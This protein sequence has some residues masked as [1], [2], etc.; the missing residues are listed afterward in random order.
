MSDPFEGRL[1]RCYELAGRRAAFE[2]RDPDLYLVHGTIE[3][4]GLPAIGHAWVEHSDGTVYE[5]A[6]NQIWP[7]LAFEGFFN[8]DPE[9]KYHKNKVN[10]IISKEG[11]WGPWHETKGLTGSRKMTKYYDD[12]VAKKKK[13][14]VDY[15]HIIKDRKGEP[16]DK[17]LYSQVKSE[18]KKKFDVYPSA[19]ANAWVVKQYKKRGGT[20]S[21]GKKKS[22]SKWYDV[23]N[24]HEA[25]AITDFIV[26]H[27]PELLGGDLAAGVADI[28]LGVHLLK[29]KILPEHQEKQ[30]KKQNAENSAHWN[31]KFE[32]LR[33]E[34]TQRVNDR[35]NA[36]NN[37]SQNEEID[38]DNQEN[39]EWYNN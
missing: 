19:V 29:N 33:R 18:A 17:E 22:S 24:V 2:S 21:K 3:N 34:Q 20:Y 39:S 4:F 27:K 11:H 38:A 12:H 7:K 30:R 36:Q 32:E 6:T 35:Y 37:L 10:K 26:H 23:D 9:V 25:G 16:A 1:G 31:N 8:P 14:N 15:D 28:G 13:K 5:P